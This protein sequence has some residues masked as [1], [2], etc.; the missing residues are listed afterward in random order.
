MLYIHCVICLLPLAGL[1]PPRILYKLKLSS[2]NITPEA[3]PELDPATA[4]WI[5]L[6]PVEAMEEPF[7]PSLR[8]R[9]AQSNRAFVMFGSHKQS[10]PVVE[11]MRDGA[12]DFLFQ[13]ES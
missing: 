7:W 9:L 10:A 5:C 2:Q 6:L 11:A 4:N 3:V 13:D 1:P 12:F 8:V